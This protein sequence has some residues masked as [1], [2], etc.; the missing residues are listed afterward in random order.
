MR[1]SDDGQGY[2]RSRSAQDM[3]GVGGR[4]LHC[5]GMVCVASTGTYK[6]LSVKELEPPRDRDWGTDGD[7]QKRPGL[8]EEE[9]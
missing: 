6:T 8:A 9:E 4:A 1:P 7:I 2:C 3:R 5:C